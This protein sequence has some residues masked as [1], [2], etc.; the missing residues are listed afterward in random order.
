M[1][2]WACFALL[3]TATPIY[4]WRYELRQDRKKQ[5]R[6]KRRRHAAA[7]A[8]QP[9]DAGPARAPA[10]GVPHGNPGPPP[11]GAPTRPCRSPGGRKE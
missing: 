8:P 6:R 7:S 5:L 2:T 10:H 4:V 9:Q 11:V 3:I 1:I